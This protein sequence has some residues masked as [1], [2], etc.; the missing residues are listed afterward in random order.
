MVARIT[1]FAWTVHALERLPQRGLTRKT[2]ERAVNDLH[3]LRRPNDGD[4]DWR[5][6]AVG[7]V[8]LYVHPHEG[9]PHAARIVTVWP[10]RRRRRRHLRLVND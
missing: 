2:V 4:A 1:R 10:K 8:V 6:D 9:D 3:P 5:I 7:F